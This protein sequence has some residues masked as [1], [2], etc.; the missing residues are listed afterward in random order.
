MFIAGHVQRADKRKKEI[1]VTCNPPTLM[2]VPSFDVDPCC[3]C[4]CHLVWMEW[5]RGPMTGFLVDGIMQHD[6]PRASSSSPTA[7]QTFQIKRLYRRCVHTRDPNY[8]SWIPAPWGGPRKRRQRWEF[9]WEMLFPTRV[10]IQVKDI[11]KALRSPSITNI[12][13]QNTTKFFFTSSFPQFN[14]PYDNFLF[15]WETFIEMQL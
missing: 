4:E 12:T 2:S 5:S 13:K 15:L 7:T 3:I 8:V 11:T 6:P 14:Y 1:K 9:R 10:F